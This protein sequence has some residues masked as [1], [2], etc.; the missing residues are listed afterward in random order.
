M[1]SAYASELSC[2]TKILLAVAVLSISLTRVAYCQSAEPLPSQQLWQI[3]YWWWEGSGVPMPVAAAAVDLLYVKAGQFWSYADHY[4][5]RDLR[6]LAEQLGESR[7]PLN[8]AAVVEW[9][10][11]LPQANAYIAVWRND[12]PVTPGIELVPQ[13]V[14]QYQELQSRAAQAGQH[15]VGVQIDH[16]C[17]SNLLEEYARFLKAL[18]AALPPEALISITALLDWFRPDTRI[19]EVLRWVNEY[20]PQF[21]D[22]GPAGT[23]SDTLKITETIDA[24]KWTPVFNSY[25]RSYRIG[26]ATFGRIVM[27]KS[28]SSLERKYFRD[29][30]ALEVAT[31]KGF[32]FVAAR[33]NNTGEWIVQYQVRSVER[34]SH[35]PLAPGDMV[36]M[37]L[38]TQESVHTAYLTAKA[39]GGF[40]AGVVFFRWP[41]EFESVLLLPEEVQDII[42]GKS[43]ASRRTV[44][45]SEDGECA[46]VGCADLYL[47]LGDRFPAKPLSLRIDVSSP[48][49]YILPA[50]R[51]N[52]SIQGPRTLVVRLPAY[53]GK[54]RMYL[55][56]VVTRDQAQFTVRS[57]P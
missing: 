45:E 44:I 9:P 28:H 40:C 24:A 4:G 5:E 52:V 12:S 46:V 56:R 13:L 42:S 39:L 16:D 14:T 43:L 11:Q 21:Y 26:I 27:V 15:L 37:I 29:L 1:A 6:R 25:G 50:E 31:K 53:V 3:G 23:D 48:V 19:A 49:E 54:P 2:S 57:Q 55:G 38:P 18:R 30:G 32:S 8:L 36:E 7:G 17:P 41:G 35:S 51:M 22:V 20:V 34:E 10:A 33:R 47:R